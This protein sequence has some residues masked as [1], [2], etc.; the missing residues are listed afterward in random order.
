VASVVAVD[1][2]DEFDV[3]MVKV[4]IVAIVDVVAMHQ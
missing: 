2:V 1:N 3:V 4:E